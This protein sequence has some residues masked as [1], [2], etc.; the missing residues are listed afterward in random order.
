VSK[1]KPVKGVVP[2]EWH[3]PRL[4]LE[5][6][7]LR[8]GMVFMDIGCGDG[9]F[10]IPA[11]I[12]VGKKGGVYAVDTDFSAINRLKCKAAKRGLN[13]VTAL[14]GAAEE[15]IFC[16][17]CADIIFYSIVLHDFR[18]PAQVLQ[19]A[20]QMLKSTGTL[21][22]IDWKK[23]LM[24]LGPPVQIRFSEEQSSILIEQAGFRIQSVRDAGRNFYIVT[25]KW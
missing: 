25:A 9:F 10:T 8:Q 11:A 4:D 18:D 14:V 20:K 24:P 17:R 19:N 15:T 2:Q 3:H 5:N 16:D 1:N 22:N 13:N 12:L 6:I 23:R 21:V 7:G